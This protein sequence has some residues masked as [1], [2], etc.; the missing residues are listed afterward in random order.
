MSSPILDATAG[1]LASALANTLVFPL[2]VIKTRIQVQTKVI[3][4]QD[5]SKQYNSTKDAFVKILEKEGIR[6]L[7]AGLGPGLTGTVISA[8]SYYFIYSSVR[9]RYLQSIN[10]KD[11]STA[12]ELSL[13]AIAGAL[14][15]FVVLPIGVVTT[16]Q[17]TSDEKATVLQTVKSIIREDGFQELWKGLQASLVLCSNPA[18][19]FGVFERIRTIVIRKT[20][21]S[22]LTSTQAFF[23]G[24]L[25]KGLATVVTYPYIMAKV[26]MQWKAPK[27]ELAKLTTEQQEQVHYTS[28]IDILTK[29]YLEQGILGWYNVTEINQGMSAQIIKAVLCQAIVFAIKEKLAGYTELIF[30]LVARKKVQT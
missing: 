23:I 25:A 7:Y 26:R 14:C 18:I 22:R 16:R 9:G 6:G 29:I 19:T 5:K 11:I 13:G 30:A 8:F 3:S 28:A 4:D 21:D 24:A 10:G 1:A 15:Q 17:Q 12:M 27:S 20:D 2:D